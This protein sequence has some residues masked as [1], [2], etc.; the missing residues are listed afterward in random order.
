MGV[1][2]HSSHRTL[3][4]EF[5][6]AISPSK[7]EGPLQ[8]LEFLGIVVDSVAETL[9]ISSA[10]QE[11]LLGLLQAFGKRKLAS[12]QRPRC[13]RASNLS[14]SASSTRWL[15]SQV[16]LHAGFRSDCRYWRDHLVS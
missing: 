2:T 11:E 7:F 14:C 12:V 9:E 6:L 8:R 15:A 16:R 10:R 1:H 13:S 3:L 4:C 5:G